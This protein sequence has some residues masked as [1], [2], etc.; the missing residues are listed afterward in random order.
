MAYEGLSN[1]ERRRADL[2]TA[3][4]LRACARWRLSE[5]VNISVLDEVFDGLDESGMRRMLEVLQ[6]DIAEIGSVFVVTHRQEL[7]AMF[8]GCRAIKVERH[9]GVSRVIV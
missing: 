8:P 3:L 1:G 4:A 7:K 5:S 2:I 9:N 6:Q